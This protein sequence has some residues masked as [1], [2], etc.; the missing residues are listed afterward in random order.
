MISRN[1]RKFRDSDIERAAEI[2]LAGS[3]E[4]HGFVPSSFWRDNLPDLKDKYLPG[5]QGYVYV[6]DAI[7]QGILVLKGDF[8]H[9]LFV[10]PTAQRQG[11]GTALI[12]TI[13]SQH[14]NLKLTVYVQNMQAI[15]FYQQQGFVIISEGLDEQTG[16]AE[17]TM[18]WKRTIE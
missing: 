16:C 15:S 5:A 9:L 11:I 3:I 1:I 13:Q 18:A 6:V 8:I 14:K 10:D 4:A 17:Y 7:I 12:Q 2:W